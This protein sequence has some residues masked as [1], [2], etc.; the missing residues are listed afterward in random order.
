MVCCSFPIGETIDSSE[1]AFIFCVR[2]VVLAGASKS[3]LALWGAPQL[4]FCV[5]TGRDI[6][7]RIGL[8]AGQYWVEQ[9]SQQSVFVIC[10][11][12]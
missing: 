4:P 11:S 7:I 6:N 8:G 1:N 9:K 5:C 12:F 10:R 3:R 2:G